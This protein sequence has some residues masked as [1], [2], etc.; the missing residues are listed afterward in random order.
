MTEQL[1]RLPHGRWRGGRLERDVVLRP[2]TGS[3]ELALVEAA[4]TGATPAELALLLL[5]RLGDDDPASLVAGDIEVT[6]R[7][8]HAATLGPEVELTLSCPAACGETLEV[9]LPLAAL[10][11]PSP[12]PPETGWHDLGDMRVRLPTG[13]DLVSAGR[14]AVPAAAL[15][16][17]IGL[18]PGD[19]VD[20]AET[21]LATCDPNADCLI[22]LACPACAASAQLTVDAL[23]LLRRGLARGGDIL[24]QVDRLARSYG[25]SEAEILALPRTRRQRYLTLL[26]A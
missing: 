9:A 26:D 14:A 3:D 25:W 18:A 10:T 15:A 19:D 16:S 5:E 2:I 1:V 21:L 24:M 7:A 11:V 12:D 13:G 8:V 17:A 20:A 6:L 22:D 4:A 23:A